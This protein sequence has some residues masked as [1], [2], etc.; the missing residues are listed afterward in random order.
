MKI[1]AQFMPEDLAT[2]TASVEAA[3]DAGYSRAYVVDGQLLWRNSIVYMT[4]GLAAT[5]RLP[6]GTA[7]VNPFTRHWTVLA[8]IHASLAELHPGRVILGIGRGDNSVRTIGKGPVPTRVVREVVPRLRKLM[9][10]GLVDEDGQELQ[11]R[12]ARQDVQILMAGTG[13]KNLRAAGALADI[14]MIQVG[15]HPAAVKWAIEHVKAGAEDAGRDPDE[16]ETTIYT[17]MWVSDD[18]DEARSMTKWAAACAA[19]HIESVARSSKAHGMPQEM[20][21]ILEHRPDH[22]DYAG[23]LD[24]SVDRSEYPDDIVDDFGISGP[25]E[26]CIEKLRA[27]AAVGLDEVAPAYLNGRIAEMERVGREIMPALAALPA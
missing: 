1:A 11:I 6:F 18:L 19:N 7:V 20:A 12:W 14:A 25:P 10:G 8:N 4:H 22:Y 2:F 21:R 26:R 13:P 24:P 23:H 9:A 27:L 16:V 17:A 5:R 15:T 3:E